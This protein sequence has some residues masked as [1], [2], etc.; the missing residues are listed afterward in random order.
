MKY[1]INKFM[2][3]FLFPGYWSKTTHD[4]KFEEAAAFL[5]ITHSQSVKSNHTKHIDRTY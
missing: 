4:L 5:L 1:L 3:L 2:A